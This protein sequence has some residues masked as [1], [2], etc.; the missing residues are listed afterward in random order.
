[1]T[2]PCRSPCQSVCPLLLLPSG[3]SGG[4]GGRWGEEL[5]EAV[6]VEGSRW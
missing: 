4:R 5:E 2:D 1:M 3:K 6:A